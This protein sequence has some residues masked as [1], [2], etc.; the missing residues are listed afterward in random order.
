MYS[1]LQYWKFLF[2]SLTYDFFDLKNN[3]NLENRKITDKD[4]LLE[5][6]YF[7]TI[8]YDSSDSGFYGLLKLSS[9][10]TVCILATHNSSPPT[11]EVLVFKDLT[12]GNI[13]SYLVT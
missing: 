13:G 6:S 8:F 7:A 5:D 2:A 10:P 4:T 3:H 11:E 12:A 9:K 1:N